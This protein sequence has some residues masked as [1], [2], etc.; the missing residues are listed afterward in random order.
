MGGGAR[1]VGAVSGI[2]K[3]DHFYNRGFILGLSGPTHV[4]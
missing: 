1:V 2:V 3:Y 4:E